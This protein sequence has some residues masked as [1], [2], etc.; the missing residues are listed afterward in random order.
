MGELAAAES[1]QLRM[2]TSVDQ[3]RSPSNSPLQLRTG[4]NGQDQR[5]EGTSPIDHSRNGRRAANGRFASFFRRSASDRSLRIPADHGPVIT[6]IP[7]SELMKRAG[8]SEP[9]RERMPR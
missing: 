2:S 1:E 8:G 5:V 3:R 7:L 4:E 6:R 9:A